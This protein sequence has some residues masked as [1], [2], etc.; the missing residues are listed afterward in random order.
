MGKMQ[1]LRLE[2]LHESFVLDNKMIDGIDVTNKLEMIKH[3]TSV[4]KTPAYLGGK[5]NE[6]RV[7]PVH[8]FPVPRRVVF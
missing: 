3:S 1:F 5:N 4:D 8:V 7:L 6:W 2:Y